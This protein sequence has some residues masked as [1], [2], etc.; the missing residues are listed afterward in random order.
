MILCFPPF[1]YVNQLTWLS[2]VLPLVLR[3]NNNSIS[4]IASSSLVVGSPHY[5]KKWSSSSSSIHGRGCHHSPRMLSFVVPSYRLYKSSCWR[6]CTAKNNAFVGRMTG[7]SSNDE[8]VIEETNANFKLE[9]IE[10]DELSDE[11]LDFVEANA[12][13]I[14]LVMREVSQIGCEHFLQNY[15]YGR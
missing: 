11:I 1:R 5:T 2:A 12:P 8:R 4:L 15:C 9:E 13:P 14:M 6:P 7:S 3:W 10:D